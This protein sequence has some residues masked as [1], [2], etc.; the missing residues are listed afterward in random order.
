MTRLKLLLSL[1]GVLFI[2]TS[3]FNSCASKMPAQ[4]QRNITI[5]KAPIAVDAV[6]TNNNG[7]IEV[8]EMEKALP[9]T[10]PS[11]ISTLGAFGAIA[12]AVL[13]LCLGCVWLTNNVP[14]TNSNV[15]LLDIPEP[16][17]EDQILEE[18]F[19]GVH[20]PITQDKKDGDW[21]DSGQKFPTGKH[22]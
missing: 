6:D 1:A 14:E 12:G 8:E 22:G 3:L 17:D 11:Q 16:S 18:D 21:L 20:Q 5:P 2:M 19:D 10:Q 13:I 7:I 4:Q 9:H 15:S